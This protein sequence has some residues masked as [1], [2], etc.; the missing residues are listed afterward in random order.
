MKKEK[1][2]LHPKRY[3]CPFCGKWHYWN[4]R[5]DLSYYI[6]PDKAVMNCFNFIWDC[7]SKEYKIYFDGKYQYLFYS[8][9][10]LCSGVSQI[11]GKVLVS[12]IEEDSENLTITFEIEFT[13]EY[14][15]EVDKCKNC[16]FADMC[17]LLRMKKECEKKKES[18]L[19]MKLGFEF[20]EFE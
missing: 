17:N 12:E 5:Y 6:P 18:N 11:Q 2:K 4:W 9:Q 16:D 7:Y 14:N 3:L 19:S 13:P 8:I 1:L 20:E 10:N 15:N